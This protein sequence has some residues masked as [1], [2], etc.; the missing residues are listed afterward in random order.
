MGFC[1]IRLLWSLNWLWPGDFI[2]WHRSGS[3]LV[4][5][6]A[7]CLTAPSHY[8]NQCW[9]PIIIGVFTFKITAASFKSQWVDKLSQSKKYAYFQG[10][11]CVRPAY[12]T[13]SYIV[14][15]S[16]IGWVHKQNDPCTWKDILFILCSL[17]QGSSSSYAIKKKDELER[18]AKSNR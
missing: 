18:V 4:Q 5:V 10:S 9:L 1:S 14:T 2:Y 15:S 12:G 8:L 3:T 17:F 7:G 13:R 6:M 16:L 11:F